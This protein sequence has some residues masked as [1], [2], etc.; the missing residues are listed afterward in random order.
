MNLFDDC[1]SE[2][3]AITNTKIILRACELLNIKTEIVFDYPT[4]LKSTERLVDII[5]K[6]GAVSPQCCE[7]MV[8]NLTKISKK[9]EEIQSTRVLSDK[10]I[11]DTFRLTTNNS[12]SIYFEINK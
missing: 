2:S 6:Y 5:K 1:I 4:E 10:E 11:L 8:K 12:M 7:G 3:V 9:Y